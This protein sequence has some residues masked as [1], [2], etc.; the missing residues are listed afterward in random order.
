MLALLAKAQGAETEAP[1]Y[2]RDV[3]PIFGTYCVGCHTADAPEGELTLESFAG[4]IA[5]GV[6]GAAIVPGRADASRLIRMVTGE[7]EPVMPPKDNE[8]PTEAEIDVLRRWIDAG[9]TGPEGTAPEFPEL[10]TPSIEP[11]TNAQ[12]EIT[13][14]ALARDGTRLALG[15]YRRVEI[16]DAATGD[17]VAKGAETP[18]KVNGVQ[19]WGDGS[20]VVV[21]SGIPGLYGVAI[22]LDAADGK[23]VLE[24][25]G[26]RDAIY[27][28]KLS[29]KGD[30]LAT[31]SHDRMIHLWDASTGQLARTL[32]GHNGAV[33]RLA[34]NADGTLLA[35]ASA[36]GTVKIWQVATGERLDTLGQPEGGQC[37]VAF[38]PDDAWIVAGGADRQVR[39]WRLVSREA[40]RINPMVHASTAHD[41]TVVELAFSPDGAKLASASESGELVL[42]DVA[43]FAPVH[44]Y[45]LQP[46]VVT[47]I[48]FEANGEHFLVARMDGSQQRYA[49]NLPGDADAADAHLVSDDNQDPN[50][51]APREESAEQEPNNAPDAANAIAAHASV[52]GVI[53]AAGESRAPDVDLYQFSAKT[54]QQFVIEVNAARDK[55]P[56]DSHIEVLD[57]TGRSIPRV[58]LQALRPSYFTFRGHDSMELAD[59]RLHKWQDMELNEYLYA[60]GEVSKLWMYP[61]GPDSGFLV[62]PGIEGS[63]IAYFGTTAITHA[64]NEP[65][66]IVEPHAP[67]EQLIPNGLPQYTIYYE[68]DDDGRRQLGADSRVAFTAPADGDYLVRVRDVRSLGGD[69]YR[70][71]LIVRPPR[72]DFQIK[73]SAGDLTVGAGSG[74]EFSI[75]V[76]RLDDF[77]GPIQIHVSGLPPGFHVSSPL[78]IEAG[79]N[80]AYGTINAAP[81][82]VAPPEDQSPI[83]LTA[84]AEIGGITVT[85]NAVDLGQPK[86]APAPKILIRVHHKNQPSE[87]VET[88]DAS[89]PGEPP[90]P[91]ELEIAP[92]ETI[93]AIVELVRDGN[94][95]EITLGGD[96]SGRNLP[97]GVFIDNIGLNGLT[98]L[99]GESEREFFITAEPLVPEQSR[100]FHL[101]TEA[102]G[103]QTSW[104]VLLHIRRQRQAAATSPAET[105]AATAFD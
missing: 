59:F 7:I 5:G 74:K 42:W 32:S 10:T 75:S 90:A 98:L 25:K 104:P 8:R 47:G 17:V 12:D 96:H 72:P 86:L 26:H 83:K 46:D 64:L 92:G 44:R 97:H 40:P 80:I 99:A 56:L 91:I 101:R 1:D 103:G 18:G 51:P 93:S 24:V 14:F 6:N 82:S 33:M 62:Y 81:D 57:A 13:S 85:K 65:C 105:A 68:N 89:R 31:C 19:F 22:V 70:Y 16:R 94:D 11:A 100:L 78:V 15:K 50:D 60:N 35:S 43:R 38:S 20:R 54:G 88:V 27:D 95:G 45:E 73:A 69:D 58:V 37:A 63:R 52:R 66:Y 34:F 28:A 36:D 87:T 3:A 4:L 9:A 61:R 79:Q 77:E 23:T 67:D 84:S 76:E 2:L 48:A 71:E 55:S 29:P 49:A 21:A 41:S 102:E 53:A 39:A 30:L